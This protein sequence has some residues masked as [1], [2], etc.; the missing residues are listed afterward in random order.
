[1]PTF[2]VWQKVNT[3]G[4]PRIGRA[5]VPGGWLVVTVNFFG[6]PRGITFVSDPNHL[7]DGRSLDPVATKLNDA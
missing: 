5:S 3:I 7:W 1:M 2:F 6:Q 4:G